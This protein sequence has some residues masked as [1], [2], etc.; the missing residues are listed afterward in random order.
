MALR[1]CLNF[2]LASEA[3]KDRLFGSGRYSVTPVEVTFIGMAILYTCAV[4]CSETYRARVRTST[5]RNEP[6]PLLA[7]HGDGT[8]AG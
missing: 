4:C 7:D 1:G 2:E 6:A 8:G 3:F 5:Q